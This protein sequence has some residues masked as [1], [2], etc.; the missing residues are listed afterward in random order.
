MHRHAAIA[1]LQIQETYCLVCVV[2]A[3][4]DH[5]VH[6]REVFIKTLA[7]SEE[8]IKEFETSFSYKTRAIKDEKR[9][10]ARG[11]AC[12]SNAVYMCVCVCVCFR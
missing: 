9:R 3:F 12:T 11:Q 1:R 10:F 6:V 4:M 2:F 5:D 7:K 8:K